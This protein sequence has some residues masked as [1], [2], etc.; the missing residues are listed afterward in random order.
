[1]KLVW[2]DN[3]VN[4]SG[5]EVWMTAPG[6]PL[7]RLATIQPSSGGA[8]WT[9][10][11]AP[12]PGYFLFW[13]EAVNPLGEQGSNI[14]YLNV[15]S[16]CPSDAATQLQVEILD[17]TVNGSAERVYCYVSLENAPEV[18]LPTHDG[19]FIAIQGGQGNVTAWPH[20]FSIPIP[21]NDKLKI[22]R[23]VLGMVGKKPE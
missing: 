5:Y 9:E 12:G 22:K 3:A 13:V 11:K 6:A 20:T 21:K 1:M 23:R 10:I 19:N 2:E 8:T 4:E 17:I 16:A 14:I 7:I 18:R 15:D